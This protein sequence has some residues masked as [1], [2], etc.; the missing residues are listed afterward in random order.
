V[1]V[2]REVERARIDALLEAGRRGRTR[3]L[4]VAGEPGI[5][6]TAL[7][8]DAVERAT[9]MRVLRVTAVEAESALPFAGL[10]ALLLPL[11]DSFPCLE[12]PQERA[13]RIALALDEGDEPDVLAANAGTL[14][15]LAEAAGEQ[16][17]LLVVDDAHW[18]DQPSAEALAFALRRLEV[19]EIATVVA[20]RSGETSVFDS[21][22]DRLELAPLPASDAR[23][24][25]SQRSEGVPPPA[26]ES[27]LQLAAGNP[28]ALL[29]LP[30]TV[31]VGEVDGV[32][33]PERINRAFAA[34]LDSLPDETRRALVLAAAEPDIRAVRAAAKRLGLGE[35]AVTAAEA[36]GLVR[37]E[38]DG[39][40]FRHPIV[41][42]LA[43]SSIDPAA[44]RAAHAAL[45]AALTDDGSHDRRAWHLAAAATEADEEL[46]TLLEATADRAEARGGHSAAARALERAARLSPSGDGSARRLTRAARLAFWAGDADH[47]LELADE[48]LATTADPNLRAE[49]ILE[50]EAVRG[51]QRPDTSRR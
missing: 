42:S 1:L 12:S 49:A 30:A 40:V 32:A 17:L 28:L 11:I 48:A 44:R 22:F 33:A 6:K 23:R 50:R 13:L 43:Y 8:G 3:T 15:V 26:V 35:E 47:A 51:A 45:A 5:G 27:M 39:I 34:R 31:A 24:L 16:P 14:G 41:R 19:E 21:G 38:P 29:E 9:G 10:H 7:L 2:G 37:L 4:V 25:L 46:A 20:V 18:L 36:A